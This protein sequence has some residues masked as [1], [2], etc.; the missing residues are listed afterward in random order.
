MLR[1][2]EQ[3][4]SYATK[5]CLILDVLKSTGL[6]QTDT[7]IVIEEFLESISQILEAGKT[8][9]IRGFGTFYTKIRQKESR[10]E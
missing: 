7:K 3:S 1:D 5:H 10:L 9:E 4:M 6:S 2:E 8:I